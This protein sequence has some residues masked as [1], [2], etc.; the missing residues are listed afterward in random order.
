MR[1]SSDAL[2]LDLH[3]YS[4]NDAIEIFL[5]F[6]NRQV[7]S[8]TRRSI[9]VIHGYGSSGEGGII[10]SRLRAFLEAYPSSASFTPGEK[11]D[12]NPGYTLI[13]PYL[14]LPTK[15]DLLSLE[16]LSYCTV[17]R[18]EEKIAGKFHKYGDTTVRDALKNLE[19]QGILITQWKGKHKCYL[20]HK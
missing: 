8:G 18:S 3:T 11:I 2:I 1:R 14:T 15:L 9:E 5:D 16:I 17:A 20:V 10:R 19:R 6:Y 7:N 4:V 13:Y 12:G